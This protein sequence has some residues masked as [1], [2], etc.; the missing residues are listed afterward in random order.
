[1]DSS[2]KLESSQHE[3][4]YSKII[5][6]TSFLDTTAVEKPS[7]VIIAAQTGA[8]KSNLVAKSLKEFSDGN[9]VTVNTDELRA[10]HPRYD[11]IVMLDDTRSAE[12]THYDASNWK[13]KLLRRCFET[14]RNVVLEGVFKDSKNLL[15]VIELAKTAGYTVVLRVVAAHQRYSV[16][17]INLRYEGEKNSR[18]HGRYV[19][20]EYHDEC[21][22]KLLDSVAAAEE[23]KLVDLIE[24]YDRNGTKFYSNNLTNGDWKET[25]NAVTAIEQERNRKQTS[26]ERRSYIDSWPR[27]L[28]YMYKRGASSAEIENA[29]TLAARFIQE[30]EDST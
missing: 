23:Q 9:V 22:Q 2:F 28:E 18:E 11:E 13:N 19:P 4:I 20:I 5:E 29:K 17:G 12:R 21:Y 16:W 30:L 14:H 27:V 26:E 1:M 10:Y 8:G 3:R 24:G 6:P 15:D 25:P 7:L